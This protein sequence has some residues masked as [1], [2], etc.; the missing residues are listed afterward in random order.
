MRKKLNGE[1]KKIEI[2]EI[3]MIVW[4]SELSTVF[5]LLELR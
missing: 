2:I 3:K 5:A 4:K 1:V